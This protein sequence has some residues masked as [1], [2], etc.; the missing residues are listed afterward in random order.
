[1]THLGLMSR[2]R[3]LVATRVVGSALV[4]LPLAMAAPVRADTTFVLGSNGV[5]GFSGG[6]FGHASSSPD[7]Q[8]GVQLT[9]DTLVGS[10]FLNG[11]TVAQGGGQI[12]YTWSGTFASGGSALTKTDDL[13]L[14]T[15][16]TSQLSPS[17]SPEKVTWT[18]DAKVSDS[19]STLAE[20]FDSSSPTDESFSQKFKKGVPATWTVTLDVTWDY[21]KGTPQIE[22]NETLDFT[23]VIDLSIATPTGTTVPTTPMPASVWSGERCWGFWGGGVFSEYAAAD[24]VISGFSGCFGRRR[25]VG[26]MLS[27]W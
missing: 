23:P 27:G 22:S 10:S 5:S 12:D 4:I 7:G 11:F 24:G 20:V 6:A 18:L 3:E 19:S 8:G 14:I 9:G 25:G 13:I 16:I 26:V 2:A 21:A 17:V 1:M 15:A